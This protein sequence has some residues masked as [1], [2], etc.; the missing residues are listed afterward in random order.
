MSFTESLDSEALSFFNDIC[1]KPFAEQG[2]AFLNAYWGEIHDEADFIFHV[3]YDRIR[4]CDMETKGIALVH[5]YDEAC[6]LDFDIALFFYEQLCKFLEEGRNAEWT[7]Y[8]KS[9]PTMM[10]AIQRKKELREKVDVNFDGRVSFIEYLLYQYREF[11]NPSDFITRSMAFGDEHPEVRKARL[12][13]EEVNKAVRNYESE[14]KR[15]EDASQ[16]SGVKGLKAKN[17]LAQ[18]ESS[19]LWE[20]I[21]KSLITAEAALRMAAKKFGGPV[22]EGDSAP[23][24]DPTAGSMWWMNTELEEKK[25]RYAPKKKNA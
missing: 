5:Q 21:N 6:D 25:K 11:A 17:E 15:L 4:Y 10:T 7:K 8:V 14:K 13:L 19:P 16:L 23:S 24:S 22:G 2:K 18:L 1:Q 9:Q 3:A 20:A 12:A